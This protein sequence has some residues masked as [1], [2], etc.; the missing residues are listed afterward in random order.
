MKTMAVYLVS[1]FPF[2]PPTEQFI[3]NEL[4]TLTKKFDDIYF[5]S[6]AR[7]IDKSSVQNLEQ[8]GDKI[9]YQ[10]AKRLPV[11]LECVLGT[12]ANVIVNK[13]FYKDLH[14]IRKKNPKN[15]FALAKA[16]ASFYIQSYSYYFELKGWL[17]SAEFEKYDRI[18][19]HSQWNNALIGTNQM[20]SRYLK[21]RFPKSVIV[22]TSKSHAKGDSQIASS[23]AYHPGITFINKYI[24]KLLPIGENELNYLSECGFEKS[25]MHVCRLGVPGVGLTSIQNHTALYIDKPFFEI[26]SCSTINSNK[27]VWRIAD[28]LSL[29]NDRPIKWTHFG[30]SDDSTYA[31]L[32]QICKNELPENICWNL[33]GTTENASILNYYSQNSPDLFIIVSMTEG[34]PVAIMEAFSCGIPA[35]ATDVGGNKEIVKSGENGFLIDADFSDSDLSSLILKLASSDKSEYLNMKQN[36]FD[37]W[38]TK[39]N[40]FKNYDILVNDIWGQ[41]EI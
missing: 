15:F 25:K 11:W 9:K 31:E 8:Y 14:L 21:K 19:I 12:V 26:V 28:A 23:P 20:F 35:I 2:D 37:T 6:T 32:F 38:D 17:K 24:D 36:A 34:V 18:S 3:V 7:R 22:S 13:Y 16:T 5:L 39:Y 29:I 30:G 10:K 41:M 4:P 40:A 1:K 33:A 27:R